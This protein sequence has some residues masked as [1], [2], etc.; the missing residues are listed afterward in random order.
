MD[1]EVKF[2]L[3]SVIGSRTTDMKPLFENGKIKQKVKWADIT[4]I[5]NFEIKSINRYLKPVDLLKDIGPSC[6]SG[7]TNQLPTVFADFLPLTED[8]I[9]Q[10]L[11]HMST[12]V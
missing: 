7:T 2:F 10:C 4:S 9:L 3:E 1:M 11:L 12:N 8:D 5:E 6:C